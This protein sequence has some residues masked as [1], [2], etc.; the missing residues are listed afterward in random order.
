MVIS[1]ETSKTIEEL[2]IFEQHIQGFLA[3]KQT[4]QIE[5]QEVD[6][7]LSEINKTKDDVYKI[8]SGVMIKADKESLLKELEEKKKIFELRINSVEKQEKILEE[9]TVKLR[10]KISYALAEDKDNIARD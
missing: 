1:K 5:L 2:Q 8:L 7:A 6:N 4:V 9:K 3:Q 10:D